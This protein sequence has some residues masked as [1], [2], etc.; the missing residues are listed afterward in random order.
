MSNTLATVATQFLERQGLA[1]STQRSYE[2]TLMPLLQSHGRLP[3]EIIDRQTLEEYLSTLTQLS[4]TTHRRHQSII[5]SLFNFALEAG[6]L[7]AN[8]IARLRHRKPDPEKGEHSTDQIVRYLTP[9]QIQILYRAV[10]TDCRMNALVHILHR[11]GAR[12]SEV[13]ALDLENVDQSNHK[14]QVVGKGNKRRWCFY[15]QDA[16]QS[17]EKYVRYYRH[18]DHLALF[19]A[20]QRFSGNVTRLSYHS[21][22]KHWTRLTQPIPELQGIRLHDLR[23]TFATERVGLMGIEELR[24]LMGHDNIQTTLRYQ[25]VTSGR[26]ETVAQK[27][28][29]TLLNPSA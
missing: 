18:R 15:S 5:Q 7:K 14:F 4:Y 26:A 22:Y 29:D 19:T 28:L 2:L 17:L 21:A 13:L 3:V 16:E 8:P 12:I 6:Y 20:Q 23:H 9:Q 10:V 11:S 27:A 24:A 1:K 25:K